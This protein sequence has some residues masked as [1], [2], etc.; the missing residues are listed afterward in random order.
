[1]NTIFNSAVLYKLTHL[2]IS[3]SIWFEKLYG[4]YF[5][6][7]SNTENAAETLVIRIQ[8]CIL[9]QRTL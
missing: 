2:T 7:N 1:M 5:I 4:F 9:K 8:W 6:G 3:N